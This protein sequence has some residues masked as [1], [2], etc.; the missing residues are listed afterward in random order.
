MAAYEGK[1]FK[2]V[3]GDAGASGTSGERAAHGASRPAHAASERTDAVRAAGAHAAS[4][5]APG[6]HAA[7]RHATV[8]PAAN[9]HA[10]GGNA[11]GARAAGAH[12]ASGGHG[13]AAGAG[14][15]SRPASS[16]PRAAATHAGGHFASGATAPSGASAP[17]AQAPQPV[18][19]SSSAGRRSA[20]GGGYGSGYGGDGASRSR[21]R[22]TGKRPASNKDHS[23]RNVASYILIG[24][25]VLLLLVA[26]GIFIW[27]QIGYR[28]AS[29]M[30]SGLTKYVTVDDSD[31]S[32]IPVVDWDALKE[33]NEDIVA[34]VYVPG[35]EIN[36][37][38][39]Q[40]D[41]NDQYLRTLPDGTANNSGSI[42]LDCDQ[43]AP[44][45]VDQQTTV[46]GHHMNDS[47]M[48]NIIEK[49]LNQ[50][51]FNTISVV[52]YLTPETTYTLT[53]LFTARVPDSYVE[54]RQA[55]FGDTAAL[56]EYL[57]SL[58]EYAQAEADDVDA[59]L[60]ETDQ[61]LALVTCSGIA[62]AD[63]RAVMIC[64]IADEVPAAAATDS[65]E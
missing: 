32:G 34:W 58:R 47:S 49:T 29:D 54:A 57:T 35:T 8:A 65:T 43:T 21:R 40:G 48:F 25:G 44:G 24:I 42:M 51:T 28:Q 61:V 50:D 37:P 7:S 15:H 18:R 23:K 41:T 45:M 26:A 55:N 63:H 4:G 56:Q 9:A 10:A 16:S 19:V 20:G 3:P 1:R 14:A 11:A 13:S 12:A 52:Y 22:G 31:A 59:R 38:V 2:S 64:T 6:A 5:Y 33:E 27:A 36:Y 46:Y 17:R 53:P 39:L 30:Y 60:P 62:P